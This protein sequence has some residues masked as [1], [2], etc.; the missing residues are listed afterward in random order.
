M[1]RFTAEGSQQQLC[2][3]VFLRF[4]PSERAFFAHN[5]SGATANWKE[6]PCQWRFLPSK[7]FFD[8]IGLITKI[9]AT[10]CKIETRILRLFHSVNS[11]NS[12]E[13]LLRDNNVLRTVGDFADADTPGQAKGFFGLL[14]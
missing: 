4:S 9:S 6:F 11:V 3:V 1:G 14:G 7:R 13:S 8:R 12:V 10:H 2:Q 5:R